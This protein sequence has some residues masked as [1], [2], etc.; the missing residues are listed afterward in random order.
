MPHSADPLC[1]ENNW[2]LVLA[3]PTI[4]LLEIKT[5]NYSY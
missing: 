3:F 2:S 5:G 1:E 4:F